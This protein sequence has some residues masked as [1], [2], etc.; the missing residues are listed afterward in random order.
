LQELASPLNIADLVAAGR[1][2]N[3]TIHIHI[4]LYMHYEDAWGWN[5]TTQ[6]QLQVRLHG[7][8]VQSSVHAGNVLLL[9]VL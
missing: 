9:A 1:D 8:A 3:T 2:T 7:A 4:Y 5:F 6:E